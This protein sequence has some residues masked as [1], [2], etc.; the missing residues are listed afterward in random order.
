MK[1]KIEKYLKNALD[2]LYNNDQFLIC[3]QPCRSNQPDVHHHVGERAIVF[4]LAHYL[5]NDIE[6]DSEFANYNLDCEYNRNGRNTKRLPSFPHGTFPD[7]IIHERGTN[8]NNL[9]VC[10]VKTYW[11]TNNADDVKKIQQFI[12]KDG[13]YKFRYGLSLKITKRRADVCYLWIYRDKEDE[14]IY[15]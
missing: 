1:E 10:E 7:I 4:R 5:S 3:N 9:F 11:N 12:D 15:K 2:E 13:E 8:D 6:R 14:N